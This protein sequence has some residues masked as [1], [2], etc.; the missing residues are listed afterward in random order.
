MSMTT[1]LWNCWRK[2][3]ASRATRTHASGSSPFTWKIG[4]CTIF[5][6]SVAVPTSAPSLGAGGEADLVVDDDVH[7]AAG[8]VALE[9]REVQRLGDDALAG[10]RGVAVQQHGQHEKR[11][12][13]D[14]VLLGARH[15]FDDRVD[16]LEVR[17]VR[18]ERET[19]ISPPD[20]DS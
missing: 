2:S 1:S 11:L 9:L 8:A 16:R 17:R 19:S 12:L 18:R 6:T 5:A 4:A 15:A 3:N 14:E 7:R 20:G 10:E 13:V